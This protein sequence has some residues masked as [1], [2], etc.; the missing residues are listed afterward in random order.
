MKKLLFCL[1]LVVCAFAFKNQDFSY[2]E[3]KSEKEKQSILVDSTV[4]KDA[5]E[6]YNDKFSPFDTPRC[7]NLLDSISI[8]SEKHISFYF[9][10]FNKFLN[11]SD[12]AISEIMGKYC[13]TLLEKHPDYIITYF[14]K[15]GLNKTKLHKLY[16]MFIG[17]YFE[18]KEIDALKTMLNKNKTAQ[19]KK[20][21]IDELYSEIDRVQKQ[22]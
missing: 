14:S 10:V 19:A 4:Y 13:Y 22:R 2:W 11:K 3:S 21:V 7:F 1:G 20:Q 8:N 6:F 12:G 5:I 18:K 15:E 16:G 17:G 9:F